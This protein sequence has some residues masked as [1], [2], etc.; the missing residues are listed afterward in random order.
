MKKDTFKLFIQKKHNNEKYGEAK[1][2]DLS[3]SITKRTTLL[4]TIFAHSN[5]TFNA[6]YVTEFFYIQTRFHFFSILAIAVMKFF[7][8]HANLGRL[9]EAFFLWK[10]S[11]CGKVAG[12]Q[13][14]PCNLTEIELHKKYFSR[15]SLN[16]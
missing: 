16:L 12:L 6:I 8:V 15:I 10:S 9:E 2:F 4:K 7:N 13:H 5:F 11:F 1:N 3:L 14:N